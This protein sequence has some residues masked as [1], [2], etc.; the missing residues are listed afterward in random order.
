MVS[1]AEMEI[2][3]EKTNMEGKCKVLGTGSL[4]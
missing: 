2:S 1:V 4:N 3:S